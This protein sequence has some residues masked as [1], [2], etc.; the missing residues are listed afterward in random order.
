MKSTTTLSKFIIESERN[1]PTATGE[2]TSILND[3]AIACKKLS[4]LV[5]MGALAGVLGSAESENVQG[6]QQKKLD[7]ISNE[8][9]IE[10]IEWSGHF[11]GMA[12]EEMQDVYAIPKEYPRGRYL[13]TF[14]PLDGS[15]NIDVN[16][17]VGTIFSILRC[18]DDV[19]QPTAEDFLRPGTEQVCGGYC[20]YGSSTMLVMTT[21][22]GV[23]G[24][25]LD[26]SI[27]EFILTDR[28]MKIPEDTR[29][30][31]INMSNMRHWEAP[32]RRYIDELVAGKEG[33][34]ETDFNMR[35]IGSMVADVHRLLCRGGLFLYPMDAKLSAQGKEG[36]L[37]LLYEANPM[38]FIVEQAGGLAS[39]GRQR[40]M[41]VEPHSLHQRVPVLMGS[42]NEIQRLVDYHQE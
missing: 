19:D 29:E 12:S 10:S 7:I 39:T 38:S 26:R 1:F 28:D 15:S 22:N 16:V 4:D 11:A 33:V 42:K 21:G 30:F 14:D 8:V 20:L 2:F 3:V 37:R 24:F 9:F 18:P 23:N 36:R 27:G 6:E 34:R 35:W 31:A 5:N 40:I 25:T 41:E 32:M 17:S 13:I